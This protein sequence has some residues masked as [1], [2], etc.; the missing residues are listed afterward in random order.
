MV[1]SL[2]AND[3]I[4][5]GHK[6]LNRLI[7]FFR[8]QERREHGCWHQLFFA[9]VEYCENL[10]F[11]RR[12][13]LDQLGERLLDAN[14]NLGRP[15]KLA[16][17]FGRRVT[18][19]YQGK[20]Q[21]EI[22]DLHLGNPVMRSYYKNGFAKHYVRDYDVLRF[23]AATNNVYQDYNIKKAVENLVP[24]REKMQAIITQPATRRCSRTSWK[25]F[26][27][28]ANC[29]SSASQPSWPTASGFPDSNWTIPGNWP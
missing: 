4:R 7:P 23:E 21:T 24:L 1:D 5:C 20:L 9:Q 6:W 16:V 27:I 12:A 28:A 11:R 3:L 22:E 10:I 18:K 8:G 13:A 19:Q 2:T 29:A 25:P 26:S 15:D 14:R 17:I